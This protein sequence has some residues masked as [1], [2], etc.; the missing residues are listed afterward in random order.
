MFTEEELEI[1]KS[2]LDDRILKLRCFATDKGT[3]NSYLHE[4]IVKIQHLTSAL[5][6]IEMIGENK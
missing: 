5:T 6:K 2:T 3:E 4:T 1:V